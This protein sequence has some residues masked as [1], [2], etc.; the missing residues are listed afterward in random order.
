MTPEQWRHVTAVFHDALAH[1][2][3][4]RAAFLEQACAGET[5]VRAEVDRLLAAHQGAGQFGENPVSP[6]DA[7]DS[8]AEDDQEPH[9]ASRRR[10]PFM[11]VV[12][13]AAV[14]SFAAFAQAASQLVRDGGTVPEFGWDEARRAGGWAV[15]RVDPDGPA[16]GRLDR[17]RSDRRRERRAAV[18]GRGHEASPARDV[19]GR[20]LPAGDRQAG[21]TD[22][23]RRSPSL[24]ARTSWH[25]ASRISSSASSG[26]AS[27]CSSVSRDPN[28]RWHGW[29]S[30]PR[31]R[32]AS[33]TWAG[34][35]RAG[36]S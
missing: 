36:R 4:T 10:H 8:L 27:G 25:H 2:P 33:C 32:R 15:T 35:F 21:R 16:A 31:W 13:A 11:W 14:V 28:T 17:R 30:A 6:A 26:A 29:R 19:A 12:W 34:S 23:D 5:D 24:E 22:R 7:L 18:R 1:G 3:A 9:A 20:H